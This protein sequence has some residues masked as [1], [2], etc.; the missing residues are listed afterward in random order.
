MS[1]VDRKVL[2]ESGASLFTWARGANIGT[3]FTALLAALTDLKHASWLPR[4]G[5][6]VPV[7]ARVVFLLRTACKLRS[8]PCSESAAGESF[9]FACL[10]RHNPSSGH[11]AFN[12]F[13]IL[14]WNL[15]ADSVPSQRVLLCPRAE[16]PH[17]SDARLGSAKRCSDSS[18]EALKLRKLAFKWWFPGGVV[19]GAAKLL[20]DSV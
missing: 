14:V 16:V 19:V 6:A 7:F 15:G 18:S 9:F 2:G 8:A 1:L 10:C 11:L 12:I 5:R 20:G 3:T 13:G 4:F 17:P